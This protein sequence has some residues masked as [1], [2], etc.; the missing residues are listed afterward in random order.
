MCYYYYCNRTGTYSSRREG[1]RKLKIL[2]T[3]KIGMHCTAFIRAKKYTSG[4]V[5][6]EGCNHHIHE[7]ELDHLHLPD[8]I[9][10]MIAAKLSDGVTLSN[11]LD[12]VRDN[13][14][15]INRT[16]LLC[17]QDVHNIKHQY[18]IEGTKHHENDHKSVSL[19]V[20]SLRSEAATDDDSDN[21]VLIFKQL[22]HEQ[23]NDIDDI[24][25]NDFLIGIQ[26]CI[27]RK[28]LKKFG[29]AAICIDSTDGTIVCDVYLITILILD[30]LAG[31]PVRWIVSNRE[32]SVVLC[33]V[34]STIKETLVYLSL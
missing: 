9:R 17:C 20:D 27:Q 19:W 6:V 29:P 4:E 32:D 10:A 12:S 23:S 34:L 13:V 15:S 21:A 14:E 33:Q 5:V 8:S 7:A 11:I 3:L 26:T 24:G 28:I 22:G 30:D 1:K 18:N 16:A 31:V 25:K 2:G